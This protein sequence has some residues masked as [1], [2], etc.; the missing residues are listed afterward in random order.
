MKFDKRSNK[1]IFTKKEY[2]CEH[3]TCI[4]MFSLTQPY[5]LFKWI[6]HVPLFIHW[7]DILVSR[8]L[9]SNYI[10]FLYVDYN[11]K[12]ISCHNSGVKSVLFYFSPKIKV[13][14]KNS[15]MWWG[16][17]IYTGSQESDATPRFFF[18]DTDATP[19]FVSCNF[20]KK[21]S[22]ISC[23]FQFSVTLPISANKSLE[24]KNLSPKLP[25]LK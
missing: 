1:K 17:H 19:R 13:Q 3:S 2:H 5:W 4:N 23:W 10:N 21:Y 12:N 20:S 6:S 25:C 14:E 24:K 8:A 15:K 16:D 22:M 9:E 7:M 18:F 11:M